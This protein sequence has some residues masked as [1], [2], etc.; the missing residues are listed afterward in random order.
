M[1]VVHCQRCPPQW[2]LNDVDAKNIFQHSDNKDFGIGHTAQVPMTPV[3][4]AAPCHTPHARSSS[5]G[6]N[7]GL[8]DSGTSITFSALPSPPSLHPILHHLRH[9]APLHIAHR[10]GPG[11]GAVDETTSSI[12]VAAVL[13]SQDGD[14]RYT[15]VHC[16]H[17]MPRISLAVMPS[18]QNVDGRDVG[19][20]DPH[21]TLHKSETTRQTASDAASDA[22]NP[23]DPPGNAVIVFTPDNESSYDLYAIQRGVHV[24]LT[25]PA[26]Q[27]LSHRHKL[28]EASRKHNIVYFVE[29]HKRFDPVYSGAKARAQSLGEFNFFNTWMGQPKSWRRSRHGPAKTQTSVVEHRARGTLNRAKWMSR[30]ERK[31][32]DPTTLQKEGGELPRFP[33]RSITSPPSHPMHPHSPHSDRRTYTAHAPAYQSSNMVESSADNPGNALQATREEPYTKDELKSLKKQDLVALVTRQI[34]K[35][36]YPTFQPATT[37]AELLRSLLLNPIVRFTKT[38]TND[39]GVHSGDDDAAPEAAP[40]SSEGAWDE[41]NDGEGE[42]ASQD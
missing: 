41:V 29:H 1:A 42:P 8:I 31:A 3:S 27:L 40:E 28:I 7:G 39:A 32:G 17:V 13:S 15:G 11:A 35:W 24:L 19:A 26:T 33:P 18:S 9:M 38:I 23:N 36:P 5:T 25:K 21:T 37:T 2:P 30:T 14:C 20:H 12:S 16:T 34:D 10:K 6:T 4:Q 22:A